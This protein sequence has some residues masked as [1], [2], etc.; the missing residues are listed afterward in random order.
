MDKKFGKSKKNGY[1][2]NKIKSKN[3]K[4]TP[5]DVIN[6]ED[7]K[8]KRCK[9]KKIIY[10]TQQ[11]LPLVISKSLSKSRYYKVC[12]DLVFPHVGIPVTATNAIT[13][14]INGVTIDFAGHT[15]T[16]TDTTKTGVF[17]QNSVHV[18]VINGVIVNDP[19]AQDFDNDGTAIQFDGVQQGNVNNF[20]GKNNLD[21]VLVDNSRDI[22]VSNLYSDNAYGVNVFVR[23][24]TIGFTFRD[25][26]IRN[27]SAFQVAISSVAVEQVV[28]PGEPNPIKNIIFENLK[29]YNADIFIIAMGAILNN[30]ISVI[31]DPD[32]PYSNFQVGTEPGDQGEGFVDPVGS[33][34]IVSN[35]IFSNT[36]NTNPACSGAVICNSN[37]VTLDNVSLRCAATG[38]SDPKLSGTTL[39][40][41]RPVRN[42]TVRN[43]TIDGLGNF[44][45]VNAGWNLASGPPDKGDF[46]NDGVV[47][48]N[49]TISQSLINLFTMRNTNGVVLKN[50]KFLNSPGNAI[51]IQEN[52]AG[53][54]LVDNVFLNIGGSKLIVDPGA[55]DVLKSGNVPNI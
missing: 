1:T 21:T 50:N 36:F 5:S 30:I 34:I 18:S 26:T 54:A 37:N 22:V 25:S 20:T 23:S 43:C 40:I 48:E 11:D 33:D 28:S 35:S 38:I 32:W 8:N 6:M 7:H 14:K 19:P 12:E 4:I 41:G 2:E 10:I 27:D 49:C 13:S 29:L 46:P 15:L 9:C 55:V 45:V 51:V 17:F 44:G 39:A 31:E 53:V 47:F 52:V 3:I 42:L 16:I 24:N